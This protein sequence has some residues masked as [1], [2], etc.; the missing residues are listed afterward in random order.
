MA[1]SE[2]SGFRS[3]GQLVSALR[4]AEQGLRTG[5]L[6][7]GGLDAACNDA[8]ELYERLVVLRHKAREG[9]GREP[10]APPPPPQQAPMAPPPPPEPATSSTIKLDTRPADTRQT[11]LIEAIENSEKAEPVVPEPPT[12]IPAGPKPPPTLAE[13]LEK[14]HIDDLGKAISVS[15]KFW[16]TAELFNGDRSGFDNAIDHLNGTKDLPTALAWFESEVVA[17][18]K[19]PGDP[20]AKATFVELLKRRFA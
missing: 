19:K 17:R 14:A 8:R 2:E 5:S 16:F 3:M 9:K 12:P 7:M 4:D 10:Q 6:D 20:E 18:A 11:S 15:H 1:M 13:K